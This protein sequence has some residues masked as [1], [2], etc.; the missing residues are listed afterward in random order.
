MSAL[1]RSASWRATPAVPEATSRTRRG[2]VG[3]ILSTIAAR[4]RAFWPKDNHSARRS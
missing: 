4:Q 3:T 1:V 2:E